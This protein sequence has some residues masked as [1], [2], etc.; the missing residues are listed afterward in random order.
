MPGVDPSTALIDI[1][2]DMNSG[3][4]LQV[5]DDFE[6]RV[7]VRGDMSGYLLCDV[8]VESTG[9]IEIGDTLSTTSGNN[10]LIRIKGARPTGVCV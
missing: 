2:G 10:G 1:A 3:S 8:P 7:R 5:M 4:Q 6:G 9:V